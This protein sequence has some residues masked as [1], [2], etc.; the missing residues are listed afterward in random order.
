M[1][2]FDRI[3]AMPI[4]ATLLVVLIL[5]ASRPADASIRLCGQR[6]TTTLLAVCRN[7]IC[8]GAFKR[9][10][11]EESSPWKPAIET[12]QLFGL[13]HQ[14]KRGGIAT[15]CCEKRCSFSYLKTYCCNSRG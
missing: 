15:E 11:Y 7:Q 14:Q 10:M 13:H 5:V 12:R 3:R 6:L 1:Q 4:Y 8:G 9:A 2:W